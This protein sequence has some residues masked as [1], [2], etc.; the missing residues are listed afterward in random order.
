MG[1]TGSLLPK[2]VGVNYEYVEFQSEN[3]FAIAGYPGGN[4]IGDLN[5]P[6]AG[7]MLSNLVM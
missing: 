7:G 3:V 4:G 1:G 2:T 6:S 5:N